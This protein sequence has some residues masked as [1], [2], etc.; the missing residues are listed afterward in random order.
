MFFEHHVE[1]SPFT[2]Q[3][4]PEDMVRR[5]ERMKIKLT[6]FIDPPGRVLSQYPASNTTPTGRLARVIALHRSQKPAEAL[7]ILESL[8]K[9]N[10]DPYLIELKGQ[11]LFESGRTADASRVYSQALSLKPQEDLIRIAYVQTLLEQPEG[12]QQSQQA[13]AELH[14]V[15]AR[16]KD[17]T[18]LWRLKATA[19]GRLGRMGMMAL[20]LAEEAFARRDLKA[21]KIQADRALKLLSKQGEEAKA[22]IRA[23]DILNDLTVNKEEEDSVFGG[24]NVREKQRKS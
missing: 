21:A 7:A 4:W 2:A 22:R 5:Y 23:E 19:Y 10:P 13:L 20:M 8:I 16:E 3:S 6:A 17:N 18:L 1:R 9:G 24:S 15:S 12:T 11:I 14:K